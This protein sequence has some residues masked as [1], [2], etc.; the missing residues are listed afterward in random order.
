VK[1]IAESFDLLADL[2]GVEMARVRDGDVAFEKALRLAA[3]Y[4]RAKRLDSLAA[5]EL[6]VEAEEKL[7]RERLGGGG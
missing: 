6:A 2:V 1:T 7:A 5:L 4:L 3:R